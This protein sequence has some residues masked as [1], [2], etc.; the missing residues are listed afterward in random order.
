MGQHLLDRTRRGRVHALAV[1]M[2][3]FTGP[4]SS[5]QEQKGLHRTLMR[6]EGEEEG[7]LGVQGH[8]FGALMSAVADG[9]VF[10]RSPHRGV[11][12]R[13]GDM[14]QDSSRSHPQP[15]HTPYTMVFQLQAADS[16]HAWPL[17]IHA[18][19]VLGGKGEGGGG[20]GGAC[21]Q[22]WLCE[23]QVR[24]C[25]I[26]R[27][28]DLD[29]ACEGFLQGH[30]AWKSWQSLGS[31]YQQNPQAIHHLLISSR[32]LAECRAHTWKAAPCRVY[33]GIQ[34]L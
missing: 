18:T 9:F 17:G 15:L 28:A 20:G 19:Q 16:P 12:S 27:L 24:H 31:V 8:T 26:H 7:G 5:T 29:R 13:L 21:R 34:K 25:D 10:R 23:R 32:G 3:G 22:T 11:A 4:Q 2:S 14:C 30:A 1:L 6:V 33:P